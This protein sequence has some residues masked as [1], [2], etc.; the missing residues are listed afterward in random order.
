MH[1][2]KQLRRLRW[3]VLV[4][5]LCGIAVSVAVNV[6]HAPDNSTARLIAGVPPL[7]V[8]GALELVV[9]I[10]SSSR[11]LSALRISGATIVA[12]GAAT[13]SYAQQRAAVRE[14]G[15]AMWEAMIWPVIIDGIMVVASVS[16]VEVVRKMR[17]LTAEEIEAVT[18]AAKLRAAA[19]VHESPEVLAYR[20]DVAKMRRESNLVAMN[21]NGKAQV[22]SN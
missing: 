8:Y 10:P 7:A 5:V 6:L 11:W 3:A 2:L 21:G 12:L 18:P 13:I 1:N 15:F 17:Q 22:A 20:A 4:V 14:L 9:R 19:D 16:L